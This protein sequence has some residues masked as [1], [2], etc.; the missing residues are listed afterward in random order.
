MDGVTKKLI[1]LKLIEIIQFY[2]KIYDFWR[3]L[4]LLVG[5]WVVGWMH[6]LMSRLMGWGHVKSLIIT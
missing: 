6:G 2:L 5:V 1:N 3:H 4:H